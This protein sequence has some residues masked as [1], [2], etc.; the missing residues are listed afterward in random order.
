MIWNVSGFDAVE[1]D[2]AGGRHFRIG[3]DEPELLVRAIGQAKGVSAPPP[4]ADEGSRATTLRLPSTRT[5]AAIASTIVLGLAGLGWLVHRQAQ[6]VEVRVS[7]QGIEIGTPFYGT[8]LPAADIAALSLEPALPAVQARTNGF[9]GAGA[10]R[11]HFRLAG[12]GDGRLYVETGH[13]PYL[14]VRTRQSFVFL[15]F[16]EP[17]RTRALYD[18]AARLWPERVAVPRP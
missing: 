9:S 5:T 2:L 3:T 11:G 16:E 6:P 4:P 8:T 13:P 17:E 10:L 14:L 15:N 7:T 1:L 12:L 18:E